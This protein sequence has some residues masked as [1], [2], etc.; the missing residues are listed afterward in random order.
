MTIYAELLFVENFITGAVILVLTGK[1]RGIKIQRR[2]IAAGAMLCGLYAFILFVPLHW[3][4]ALTSKLLFSAAVV[5]AVFGSGTWRGIL[6]TTGVFYIVSF[7]MGGVTIALMYMLQIPGMTG[8]G[9]FVLKGVNFVQIAAGV[10]MTWYLGNRLAGLLRENAVRKKIMQQ[11]TVRIAESEWNLR[12][13]IDTGNSLNDPV[14]GW[15][16]AVLSKEASEKVKRKCD[17]EQFEK[18]TAIPYRTAGRTGV[19]FG[20]RP[21]S[22]TVNGQSI[23]EI[24]LGFSEKNFAPWRGTEKYDLLLHQQFLEGEEQDYGEKY[25]NEW[26]RGRL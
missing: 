2:R 15:P 20:L 11:V 6:K 24:V 16:V 7:L 25:D 14:T 17:S 23:T 9:S 18:I 3:L 19:M 13:L 5:L 22:L 10:A 1:V 12:A 8:N 21:E 26:K 4:T